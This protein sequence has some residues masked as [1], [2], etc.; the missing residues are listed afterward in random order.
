MARVVTLGPLALPTLMGDVKETLGDQLETV[1]AGVLAGERRPRP[2]TVSIPIHGD[3]TDADRFLM[4]ERLRRQVRALIENSRARLEGLYMAFSPDP[5][6]NG[7]LLVGGGDLSYARGG[8]S[9]ADFQLELS[10]CYKVANQRTHRPARRVIALDRRL[11]TTARD[12]LGT[13]FS[14]QYAAVTPIA[15]HYLPV[16]ISDA[17]IGST[18]TPVVTT[19]LVTSDGSLAYVDG[20]IDGDVVDFEQAETDIP[21]AGVRILDRRGAPATE[22]SWEQVYGPDQ[23]MTAGDIPVMDNGLVRLVF[24]F[25][26]GLVD[27]QGWTGSAWVTDATV[28]PLV[29]GMTVTRARVVEWTP[30]RAVIAITG[31]SGSGGSTVRHEVFISL[32]RGWTGPRF[33]AYADAIGATG[34]AQLTVYAKSTG[35]STAQRD[36]GGAVAITN[37][38]TVGGSFNNKPWVLL[39]GPGTDRAVHVAVIQTTPTLT[40]ALMSSREGITFANNDYVS[41]WVGLGARATGVADA[42][43]HGQ[44]G[45][46]EARVVPELVAR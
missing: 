40:G 35:D 15:R 16:G 42:T 6:L 3:M 7:W 23:P 36:S 21:R 2:F 8:I 22:A 26:T 11:A 1:G 19:A 33:E 4:G 5:E 44:R 9:L 28:A 13:V 14:T 31:L 39:L 30:E 12:I 38:A 27:V 32:Q 24:T 17:V 43:A 34:T 20:L 41:V 46:I 18:R 45:L 37:G 25:A 29:T 10:D